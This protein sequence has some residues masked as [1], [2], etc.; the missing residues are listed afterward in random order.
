MF[1]PL[2]TAKMLFLFNH[3]NNILHF[4]TISN[5]HLN[6]ALHRQFVVN[7]FLHTLPLSPQPLLRPCRYVFL[8]SPGQIRLHVKICHHLSVRRLFGRPSI[9]ESCH[10]VIF[11]GETTE[12][13]ES[14]LSRNY[15]CSVLC[16]KSL[17]RPGP[18]KH[19]AAVANS[20]FWMAHFIN[21]LL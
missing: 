16:K 9:R 7:Y 18:E 3:T 1:C 8:S 14:I 6:S 17:I 12:S 13:Y 19:M 5:L 20:C 21:T 15:G 2:V 11:S 10:I 4:I